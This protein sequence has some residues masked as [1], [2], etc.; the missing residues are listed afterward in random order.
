MNTHVYRLNI[1]V[2]RRRKESYNTATSVGWR[3]VEDGIDL[4][5]VEV[6]IDAADIARR[7]GRKAWENKGKRVRALNGAVIVTAR[8]V[9]T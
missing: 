8:R 6:V 3:W 5:A 1:D 9:G 2:P 7:L 4:V